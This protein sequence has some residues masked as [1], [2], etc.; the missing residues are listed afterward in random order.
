MLG[1][2]SLRPDAAE[3]AAQTGR[4]LVP[5]VHDLGHG[6]P[7]GQVEVGAP[8]GAIAGD[9]GL[10]LDRGARVLGDGLVDR[11]QAEGAQGA[12]HHVAG[13]LLHVVRDHGP[14]DQRPVGRSAQLPEDGHRRREHGQLDRG[15]GGQG[16]H[17]GGQ[18]GQAREDGDGDAEPDAGVALAGQ[19]E[20]RLGVGFQHG[21][22]ADREAFEV[23]GPP[24]QPGHGAGEAAGRAHGQ[25][26]AVLRHPDQVIQAHV[27]VVGGHPPGGGGGFAAGPQR[28]VDDRAPVPG[29]GRPG[30][31]ASRPGPGPAG[32]PGRLRRPAPGRRWCPAP[33]VPGR[34]P[35]RR[36]VAAWSVSGP[37]WAARDGLEGHDRA[38]SVPSGPGVFRVVMTGAPFRVSGSGRSRGWTGNG[39]RPGWRRCRGGRRR[40]PRWGRS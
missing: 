39:R 38:S 9:G 19:L 34:C 22:H 12:D 24:G 29:A 33:A 21:G 8:A 27:P 5:P 36:P 13:Q 2:V 23:I 30:R 7:V 11:G 31:P 3:L 18:G 17:G 28:R 32:P 37:G 20:V 16:Q 26:R 4:Q 14:V 15:R 40:R 35:G 25:L 1:M 6:D 10:E